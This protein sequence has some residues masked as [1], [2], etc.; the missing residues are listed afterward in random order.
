MKAVAAT[1]HVAASADPKWSSQIAQIRDAG[2]RPM[3]QTRGSVLIMRAR[4]SAFVLLIGIYGMPTAAMAWS[5]DDCIDAQE[6]LRSAK[7]E[8][9]DAANAY[10]SCVEE[11]NNADD[12]S[13]EKSAIDSA[14]DEVET[15]TTKASSECAGPLPATRSNE[16]ML[17]ASDRY[18]RERFSFRSPARS[19]I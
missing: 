6:H 15:A 18:F 11:H 3:K 7:E 12:C 2:R 8:A 19:Q 13:A 4:L 17:R 1:T 16:Q 14:H 9:S 10:A 5:E